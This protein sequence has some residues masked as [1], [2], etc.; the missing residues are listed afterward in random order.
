MKPIGVTGFGLALCALFTGPSASAQQ[1]PHAGRG[2]AATC[3]TCHGSDGNSVQGVPPSLA[4][5]GSGELYQ[6]MRDFHT[7]KKPATIM[8]QQAKGYTD[9]QLKL[10]ADYFAS[11]KPAPARV[12]AKP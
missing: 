3:F 4:G 12:P 6:I 11:V 5:R 2:L 9:V 8:H 7:G 1:E 10:I